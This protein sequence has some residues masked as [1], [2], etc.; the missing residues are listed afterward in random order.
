MAR[1]I[2]PP[3]LSGESVYQSEAGSGDSF[4]RLLGPRQAAEALAAAGKRRGALPRSR[5]RLTCACSRG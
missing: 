3:Q 1:A 4:S 2:P 5:A